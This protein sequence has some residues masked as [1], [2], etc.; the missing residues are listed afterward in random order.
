MGESVSSFVLST[1]MSESLKVIQEHNATELTLRDWETFNAILTSD[2][3][4]NSKLTKALEQ[5]Q[6]QVSGSHD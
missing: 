2:S 4:P 5:Y 1:L 6:E 3:A